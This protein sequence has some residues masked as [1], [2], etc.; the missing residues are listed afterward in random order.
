MLLFL[1]NKKH[2]ASETDIS[3]S[4]E[5]DSTSSQTGKMSEK[6]I[7]VLPRGSVVTAEGDKISRG[8]PVRVL[9]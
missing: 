7:A 2:W 6:L 1:V 8:T 5:K 4:I 3:E 9:T